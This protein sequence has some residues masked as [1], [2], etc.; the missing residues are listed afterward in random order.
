V[1]SRSERRLADVII[2]FAASARITLWRLPSF[3]GNDHATIIPPF[4][5][6]FKPLAASVASFAKASVPIQDLS[7]GLCEKFHKFNLPWF[8]GPTKFLA[9]SETP[10]L[11]SI[12]CKPAPKSAT[13][14]KWKEM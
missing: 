14:R 6:D 9:R 11:C 5:T 2:I 13:I 12:Q 8:L 1:R 4:R 7:Q 10:Q 3:S